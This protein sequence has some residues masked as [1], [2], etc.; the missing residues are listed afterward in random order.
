VEATIFQGFFNFYSIIIELSGTEEFERIRKK[1]NWK[2]NV[3]GEE[4]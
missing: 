2:N 1:E 4:G 3:L